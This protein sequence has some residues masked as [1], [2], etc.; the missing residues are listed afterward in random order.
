VH[1]ADWRIGAT[2]ARAFL[3]NVKGQDV[4]IVIA[5]DGPQQGKVI[6]SFI[7]DANQLNLILSR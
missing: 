5:K 4:V 7:P 6:S 3:G 1:T 2:N